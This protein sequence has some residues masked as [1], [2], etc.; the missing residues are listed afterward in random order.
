MEIKWEDKEY[1]LSLLEDAL[2][3]MHPDTDLVV[4]PETFSTGFPS[5]EDKEHV[6][7]MAER[8][9]GNTIERIKKLS[10]IYGVAIA[11]SFIADSGGFCLTGD[12]L[13]NHQEMNISK[14][15][16]IFSRWQERIKSFQEE[17]VF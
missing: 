5:G 3:R 2:S 13:S 12:F 1:N 7:A 9:T 15:N 6:R 17:E 11:G 14:T 4:L 16:I 10:S 8:N